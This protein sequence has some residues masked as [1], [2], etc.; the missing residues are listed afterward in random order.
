MSIFTIFTRSKL[1]SL[2]KKSD[3]IFDVFT[4]TQNSCKKL[5]Q[6]IEKDASTKTAKIQSLQSEVSTL[7]SIAERNN[8]LAA[9]IEAFI[10]N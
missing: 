6:E 10:N 2:S 9:K 1:G 4:K 7:N 3:K 8:K 5:N